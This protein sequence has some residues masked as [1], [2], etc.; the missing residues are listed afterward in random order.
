VNAMIEVP[1]SWDSTL[2]INLVVEALVAEVQTR[3]SDIAKERIE[4][5]EDMF[6][7]T[8]IFRKSS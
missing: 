3:A 7:S 5:L 1:S 2:A 6:M 4:A 8:R